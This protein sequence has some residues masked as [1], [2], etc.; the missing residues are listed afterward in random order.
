MLLTLAFSQSEKVKGTYLY[1]S[2]EEYLQIDTNGFKIIRTQAC[3]AC[4][5]LN[6]GDSIAG[7]GNVT[8]FQ[9]GFIKLQSDKDSSIYKN[10]TIEESFDSGIKDSIR[11]RFIFPFKGKFRI[12][13]SSGSY[14]YMTAEGNCITIPREK[15]VLAPLIFEIHNLSLKY[16]GYY[17]EYFGRI[18]F[19]YFPWYEFKNKNTNSLLI[20]IPDLTNSYYARYFID[21]EYV[22]VDKNILFWRNRAYKKISNDLITPKIELG[23]RAID[24]LNGIDCVDK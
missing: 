9:D 24:D 11:I 3:T 21:G 18:A 12:Y 15:D 17:G 23:E 7:Q 6:E 20:T 10:T 1:S 16:N 8:Y 19:S 14:P 2:E 13:A 22:K 4:L 5:D